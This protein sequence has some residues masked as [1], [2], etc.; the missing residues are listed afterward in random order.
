[1]ILIN[2]RRLPPGGV[3]SQSPDVNTIPTAL[4]ER[5][6][7]LTGGASATYGADAVAGVVNFIMRKV[8]GVELTVGAS[9]YQH[10]ND[11]DYIQGLM[12]SRNFDYPEGN[13]GIDGKAYN[14]D[15]IMGGD[16]DGG[17]GNVT[18]YA[19]YRRNDELRQES[20]DYS[21]CAL[22]SAGTACGGSGNAIIPNFYLAPVVAN[23]GLDWG[24]YDYL[25][26]DQNSNFIASSGNV[27]N[28]API[29]HFMRPDE[30][31]SLGAFAEY[32]IL[33]GLSSYL[34]VG[35][36]HDSTRA[37]IAESGTFFNE[38]YDLEVGNSIFNASQQQY[39]M[40]RWGLSAN[41]TVG[42]YIGK[43]NVEGGPRANHLE[44]NSFRMVAGFKGD[45]NANW[46]WD[47]SFTYGSTLSSSAY[48]NDFFGPRIAAAVDGDACSQDPD[49]LTYDV[50][51]YQGVTAASAKA[52]T[53]TAILN[54]RTV[55]KGTSIF[56]TGDTGI[57]LPTHGSSIQVA[58]GIEARTES[59][60]RT[61]DEVYAK[62]LLLG[63]GGPTESLYGSYSVAEVYAEA[64]IPVLQDLPL[65]QDL[66]LDVAY[67]YSD[68]NTIGGQ[69]TY[70]LGG[71]WMPIDMMRVRAGY[72]RAV[73]AP[74]IAEM[75]AD[76]SLGLWSGSDPCSGATP[77]Y[78]AAQCA[79][80]GV[81]AAQYGS[82]AAS[83][84][85]QYNE[86]S[87]GNPNLDPE[88]ADTITF[89]VVMDPIDNLTV[90]IDYW[91]IK[92]EDVVSTVGSENI[93]EQCALYGNLCGQVNRSAAGS[94]WLGETG[95]V[96]NTLSNLGELNYA[97]VDVEAS[98]SMDVF[99]GDLSMGLLGTYMLKKETTS[100][101]N[102]PSTTYDCVGTVGG[103]FVTPEWRHTLTLGYDMGDFWTVGAKWR[104]FHG[105]DYDGTTDKIA[106]DEMGSA[107][108]Y[109][110][111]NANFE[112]SENASVLVGVNNV[113]DKEPPMVGGT[114]SS[115]ANTVAGYYDTL[116]RFLFVGATV[117]F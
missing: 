39:M 91:N 80:T 5:V 33:P 59:F 112:V 67:R 9:G 114:L 86:V 22:N 42:V 38:Q 89:G 90:S 37:Q 57:S 93:L 116:G 54:G 52:L 21:S 34:E 105:V 117:K 88:T 102:D 71:E 13:T 104:Y 103:C 28:Y 19:T 15:L 24:D 20:R 60:E 97:G 77:T 3:Y 32:E 49:C 79:N 51:Q 75:F 78:T 113:F 72:N 36:M 85:S 53:G 96:A 98:Y 18:V 58:T 92:V 73:R 61:S 81:T 62:G 111:L 55:T 29:N 84:A 110:D 94:L 2:G 100:D 6:E 48:F 109:F 69:S 46:S 115:N 35:Y 8:D 1:M 64:S 68:Y 43:R 11:N 14:M 95:Y 47:T 70:R 17:K 44:H 40:N 27:Y 10:N 83:P 16:I 26:L 108:N 107:V 99:G 65:I 82:I 25:T 56:L 30:R 45:I 63:Q 23:G 31:Y 66:T 7:V 87:G 50:F 74:N 4:V 76:Q 101:P 12:D 41:D 106:Q